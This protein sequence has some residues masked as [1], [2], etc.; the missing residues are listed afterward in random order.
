MTLE[1]VNIPASQLMPLPAIAS[2]VYICLA[3][4]ADTHWECNPSVTTIAAETHLSRATVQRAL[5]SLVDA[6]L[7]TREFRYANNIQTTS[8]YRLCVSPFPP[9]DWRPPAAS[10]RDTPAASNPRGGV[11]SEAQKELLL[12]LPPTEVGTKKVVGFS[13]SAPYAASEVEAPVE[14]P[15]DNLSAPPFPELWFKRNGWTVTPDWHTCW[16]QAHDVAR[17]LDPYEHL[18]MYCAKKRHARKTVDAW[19]WLTWF[20]AD[21]P[22]ARQPEQP[23]R[24]PSMDLPGWGPQWQVAD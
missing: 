15:S 14:T 23:G 16:E 4:H 18:T 9:S 22:K 8:R 2:S 5:T 19:D 20:T 6:E 12:H 10:N 3:G 7:V 17:N 24:R 13:L 1:Y 21:D 11:T